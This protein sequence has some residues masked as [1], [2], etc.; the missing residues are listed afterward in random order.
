MK[1]PRLIWSG[2]TEG[3][4]DVHPGRRFLA[5]DNGTVS[6]LG[7]PNVYQVTAKALRAT[8]FSTVEAMRSAAAA[9]LVSAEER[10][11]LLAHGDATA[12]SDAMLDE[13]IA[14]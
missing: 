6:D 7:A 3:P 14:S 12:D 13:L 8:G 9:G 4:G 2:P 1:C 10:M 11:R 5:P